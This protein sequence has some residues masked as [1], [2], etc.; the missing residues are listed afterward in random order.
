MG[1]ELRRYFYVLLAPLG[2]LGIVVIVAFIA[3]RVLA[4]TVVM[5]GAPTEPI[6]FDHSVHVQQAGVDCVFCHRTAT[7][8]GTAGYPDVQQCMFCH[9]G[10]SQSSVGAPGFNMS[11]QQAQ[12][13]IDKVR[14]AWQQQKPIDWVRIHRVPDH[15]RFLHEAHIRA[16]FQCET[17]HGDVKN[18][19][20]VTQVRAL[21]MGDCVTCHRANGAPTECSVCHK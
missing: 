11:A 19:G 8:A 5:R 9:S 10:V 4:I 14:Q 21:N 20:Q 12:A 2:L 16:G 1:A 13:E 17:C 15:V 6:A 7:S 3:P 18:M